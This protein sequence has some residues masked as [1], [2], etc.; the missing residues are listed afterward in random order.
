MRVAVCAPWVPPVR[1]GI[2]LQSGIKQQQ[3]WRAHE[4]LSD[5]E[6]DQ[7]T[8]VTAYVCA[9]VD[10]EKYLVE[11]AALLSSALGGAKRK[12]HLDPR[13]LAGMSRAAPI[14]VPLMETDFPVKPPTCD[15]ALVIVRDYLVKYPEMLEKEADV[16]VERAL[17]D[18]YAPPA[19]SP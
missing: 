17:L 2:W 13:M 7:A 6:L 18:A 12:P 14:L 16:I 3:R 15:D 9:V 10:L 19:Q 1:D 11:R 4:T 5:K 8:L